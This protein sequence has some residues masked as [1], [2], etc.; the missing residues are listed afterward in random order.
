MSSFTRVLSASLFMLASAPG[1][2]SY[3]GLQSVDAL[4]IKSSS[5]PKRYSTDVGHVHKLFKGQFFENLFGGNKAN[6]VEVIEVDQHRV[7]KYT[8]DKNDC[9]DEEFLAK[10]SFCYNRGTC[11]RVS[12]GNGLSCDYW[13]VR[14]G[15]K[16]V[17]SYSSDGSRNSEAEWIIV[18]MPLRSR[19]SSGA[20]YNRPYVRNRFIQSPVGATYKWGVTQ[21]YAPDYMRNLL[22]KHAGGK[23]VTLGLGLGSGAFVG[24]MAAGPGW[25]FGGIFA[26]VGSL[27]GSMATLGM[28]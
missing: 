25:V 9:G 19:E 7:N 3:L 14:V 20:M 26:L 2:S 21:S 1:S 24:S 15:P 17:K 5:T 10:K 11:W 18:K 4:K 27:R 16:S 22:G 6:K 23:A 12:Y 28:D 8:L 13:K